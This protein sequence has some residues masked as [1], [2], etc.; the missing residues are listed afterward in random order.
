L[1]DS[2]ISELHV[3]EMEAL[4][5]HYMIQEEVQAKLHKAINGL[6][7]KCKQVMMLTLSE[8]SVNEIKELMS[9]T[10]NTIKTHK[11]KAYAILRQAL[12]IIL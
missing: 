5:E 4:T 11:K 8:H 12:K 10:E 3:L 1:E 2:K 9:I 6:P 7:E